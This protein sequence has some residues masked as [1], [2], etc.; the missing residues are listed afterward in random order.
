MAH[1]LLDTVRTVLATAG[2]GPDSGLHLHEH[3]YG[4][5]VTWPAGHL[6]QTTVRAHTGDADR[7]VLAELS[8]IRVAVTTALA[9]ALREAGL[10]AVSH[11]DGFVLTTRPL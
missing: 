10:T 5:I 6:V 9:T 1:D 4:V 8:H 3:A 7:T 2:Y 11:P